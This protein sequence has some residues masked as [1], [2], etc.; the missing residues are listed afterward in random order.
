MVMQEGREPS[1]AAVRELNHVALSVRD[2]ETSLRFYVDGLGMR[3]TLEKPVSD[4]VWRV[5]RLPE[6]TTAMSVFV[7]GPTAVG[8]LELVQW[9]L[10]VPEDTRPKRPGDPGLGILSFPVA[11]DDLR[12]VHD[13]L[14]AM[15]YECYSEPFT[16]IIKNYGPVSL[17]ACE[18][19]DGNQVELI[20]MPTRDEVRA[21][22]AA[23]A[24]S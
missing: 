8:Q 6:G 14:V 18:D 24:G 2:L 11:K 23:H 22:R 3:K 9:D 7:Q 1:T 4:L 12:V 19:P 16:N 17:F 15:G 10:P 13:R 5:L 21:F 20:S